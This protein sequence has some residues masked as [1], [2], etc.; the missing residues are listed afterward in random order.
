M[1]LEFLRA[2]L[3]HQEGKTA[4][5]IELAEQLSQRAQEPLLS[6]LR[7]QLDRFRH[8]EPSALIPGGG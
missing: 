6:Q 5:A 3:L 8:A 7:E 2:E 4:D 1:N